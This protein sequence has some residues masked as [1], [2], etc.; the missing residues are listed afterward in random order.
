M[1][2]R[3]VRGSHRLDMVKARHRYRAAAPKAALITDAAGFMKAALVLVVAIGLG[4]VGTGGTYAYLNASVSATPGTTLTAG[5]AALTV[6]GPSLNWS[7]LA[8]GDAVAGTFTITNTGDVP[9]VL[10]AAI[11]ATMTPS[12]TANPFTISVSNGACPVSG[13]PTGTLNGTLA[14]G[15]TT[16]ACLVVALPTN[17]PA[18]AQSA[19]A[20][21]SATISGIQP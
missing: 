16:N 17:A 6:G 19:S 7:A 18:N 10:S 14:A 1:S 13:L 20:A 21:I 12:S 5:T 15:A 2:P 4:L 9:L 8:P 3:H 11:T